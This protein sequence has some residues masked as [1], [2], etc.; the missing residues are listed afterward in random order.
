MT[1]RLAVLVAVVVLVCWV[2]NATWPRD[3]QRALISNWDV[4][5]QHILRTNSSSAWDANDA[6]AKL[7]WEQAHTVML[8][9]P[10][11]TGLGMKGKDLRTCMEIK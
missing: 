2:V 3:S 7:H 8:G 5:H 10:Q 4:C 9:N 11:H 1:R 6:M